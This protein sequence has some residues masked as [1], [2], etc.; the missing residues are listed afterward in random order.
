MLNYMLL[1]IVVTEHNCVTAQ[2]KCNRCRRNQRA[3]LQRR[4]T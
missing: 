1:T 3:Q 2:I 4:R